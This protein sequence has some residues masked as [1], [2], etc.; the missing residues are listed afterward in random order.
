[1]PPANQDR[2]EPAVETGGHFG[3][4][5]ETSAADTVADTIAAEV[6]IAAL[7]RVLAS[8]PFRSAQRTRAFLAYVVTET[9]A[10]RG[11]RIKERTVA[12]AALGRP[13][14]FDSRLDSA[15]RVQA[16]RVRRAL[17]RYYLTEGASDVVLIYLPAGS[18]V[19]TF[20]R[21]D[22]AE[23]A[24]PGPAGA[25]GAGPQP[26]RGPDPAVPGI[27]ADV[28]V[29][30]FTSSDLDR[31]TA[32]GLAE[33][34]ITELARFPGLRVGGPA[35]APGESDR[36]LFDAALRFGA[37]YLL[38]GTMRAWGSARRVSV[39]LS[40]VAN[41][42]LVW[43]EAYD[44]E[45][46][47]FTGFAGE[48]DVVRR[49]AGALGDFGGA[50]QRDSPTGAA[51]YPQVYQATL[52]FYRFVEEDTPAMWEQARHALLAA[53]EPDPGNATLL[54]MLASCHVFGAMNRL[55]DPTS[56]LPAGEE[57]ARRAIASDATNAHAHVVLAMVALAHQQPD[58]ARR[59][60]TRAAELAP[61]H[62]SSLYAA[63]LLLTLSGDWDG[64]YRASARPD[65]AQPAARR[66]AAHVP[67]DRLTASGRRRG[68]PRRGQAHPSAQR[69]LGPSAAR[70]GPVR[71]GL[72]R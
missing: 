37:R 64:R 72:P 58:Q 28:L 66:A 56:A 55:L 24:S 69:D 70:T 32:L 1:M 39:R 13:A 31:A 26:G 44:R 61:Y 30:P 27:V 60:A 68:G 7:H 35:E 10:G 53:L 9:L 25:A 2:P 43:S 49:I 41:R 6:V 3:V 17:E 54:A 16:G 50:L 5:V 47:H 23:A 45:E 48:D 21:R 59:M 65:P 38:Q 71:A 20:T 8:E 42:R 52:T 46:A 19:P 12:R 40:E 51:V 14:D 22:V 11:D 4:P 67:G 34:L 29:A 15:T 18:Y 33:S 62:P 63:G 36:D 57:L